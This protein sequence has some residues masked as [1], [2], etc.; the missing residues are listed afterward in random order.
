MFLQCVYVVTFN[1]VNKIDMLLRILKYFIQP[2][3]AENIKSLEFAY[4]CLLTS[5]LQKC[6]PLSLMLNIKLLR[7]IS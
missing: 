4:G 7:P 3:P 2:H 6:F 1:T 5:F